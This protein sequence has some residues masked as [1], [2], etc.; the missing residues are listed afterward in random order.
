M[1]KRANGVYAKALGLGAA[2]GVRS[3]WGPVLLSTHPK[4]ERARRGTG[5]STLDTRWARV[6]LG[7]L[8]AGEMV[9]DKTS[10]VPPRTEFFPLFAR[11]AAGALVGA[12]LLRRKHGGAVVGA[13]L[14]ASAAV[15]AAYGA[16]HLRRLARERFGVPD[17][18]LGVLEDLALIGGSLTL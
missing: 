17:A 2:S 6:G 14:G 18:L 11:A 1:A 12:A 4:L 3:T 7:V 8:A 15:V 9:A 5:W 16:H 10:R 13:L